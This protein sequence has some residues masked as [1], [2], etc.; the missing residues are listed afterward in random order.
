MKT[1]FR[2]LSMRRALGARRLSNRTDE[3]TSIERQGEQIKLTVQVRGDDLIHL[4]QDTDV[5]GA[6]SPFERA[7]LGPWLT[8]PHKIAQWDVLV[9]AKLDRLTRSL[10]HFNELV[11]WLDR[12]EKTLVSVSESL[13]L[14]TPTGR[15]FANLLAMFAQFERERMSERRSDRA[16]A[17]K[18]RGWY[19]G[20]RYPYGYK[21][22]KIDSHWE[23]EEHPENAKTLR[24][25]ADQILAG[26]SRSSIATQ[27][28]KD[29]VPTP[30]VEGRKHTRN[31]T[32]PPAKGKWTRVT[33][34][35][36]LVGSQ[37][38][39]D[40][41]IRFKMLDMLDNTKHTFTRRDDAPMLLNVAYCG[42]CQGPFYR[43]RTFRGPAASPTYMYEYYFCY[44][45]CGAKMIPMNELDETVTEMI[46]ETYPWVPMVETTV[47]RGLSHLAE[48][49]A[50]ER[51]IRELDLDASDY[52]ERHSEL[53]RQRA[54]LKDAPSA[55]DKFGSKPTGETAADYWPKLD[56]DGRRQF[57][58]ANKLKAFATR[59]ADGSLSVVFGP[60][61][62]TFEGGEFFQTVGALSTLASATL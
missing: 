6:V 56:K 19:G 43:R 29:G 31:D 54:A 38:L 1:P 33:V 23:L 49:G 37:E 34:S 44:N 9:V 50:I 51:Q 13:D 15:M 48:I 32:T 30:F 18:E 53:R 40:E 4:T 20:G 16:K 7:D 62:D 36:I 11:S 14:S 3:S 42:K 10:I 22:V 24:W 55:P 45:R 61:L 59:E 47:T 57:L 12:N 28:Q 52:D 41:S 21:P 27:L 17:D 39:I 58:L 35:R 46:L 5:S 26:R 60:D 2:L 25:I 8:D